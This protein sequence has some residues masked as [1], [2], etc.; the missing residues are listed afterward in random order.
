MRKVLGGF[1]LLY[2]F[3]RYPSVIKNKSTEWR[4]IKLEITELIHVLETGFSHIQKQ[5][6]VG[7]LRKGYCEFAKVICKHL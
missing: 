5:S 7:V 3:C 2:K 1:Y 6:R 4:K